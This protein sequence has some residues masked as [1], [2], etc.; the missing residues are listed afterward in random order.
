MNPAPHRLLARASDLAT[1][2]PGSRFCRATLLETLDAGLPEGV[3]LLSSG[4]ERLVRLGSNLLTLDPDGQPLKTT[5]LTPAL[6]DSVLVACAARI[7][8]QGNGTGLR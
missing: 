8:Q 1:S 6:L 5:P 2:S 3:T 4:R 7:A